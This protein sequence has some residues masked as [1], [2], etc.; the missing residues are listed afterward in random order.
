MSL[1]RRLRGLYPHAIIIVA[2]AL[3]ASLIGQQPAR[4]QFAA[5]SMW[6]GTSGGSANAQTISVSN[7]G[8]LAELTG[9]PITFLP[10][11]TNTAPTT[12]NPSS[13]GVTNVFRPTPLGAVA[14]GGGEFIASP[15]PVPVTVVYDG[16]RFQ[17]LAG[18]NME[19]PGKLMDYAGTSCPA[20]WQTANAQTLS[21]TTYATLFGILGTTWGAASGGT[22]TTPDLQNRATFGRNTGTGPRI[23]VAGGTFD[24]T[25]VGNVGGVQS[26]FFAQSQLPNVTVAVGGTASVSG[27]AT[28]SGTLAG[29]NTVT[30]PPAGGANFSVLCNPGGAGCPNSPYAPAQSATGTSAGTG[31]ITGATADINGAVTQTRTLTLPPA[32]IVSK[33][34]R[35]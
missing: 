20:G 32:A 33:C 28:V 21:Q 23:T 18:A 12:I 13:L 11:F 17:I 9:V 27:S 35:T 25:V 30:I 8:S 1:M 29:V 14:L 22:F 15:V 19:A 24:G 7:V 3:V 5:Q 6:A 26:Q 16:T 4:T 10:G 34:I 2:A 31:S